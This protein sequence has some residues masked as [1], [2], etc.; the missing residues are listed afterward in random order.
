VTQVLENENSASNID[1]FFKFSSDRFDGV[2]PPRRAA[3]CAIVE[4]SSSSSLDSSS[5]TSS[6]SNQALRRDLLRAAAPPTVRRLTLPI[7]LQVIA[8]SFSLSLSDENPLLF[9]LT[10]IPLRL[11]ERRTKDEATEGAGEL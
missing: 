4:T 7:E 5:L 6:S 11:E 9:L 10:M 2:S 8:V 3:R 1:I